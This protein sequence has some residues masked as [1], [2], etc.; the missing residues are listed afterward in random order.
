[1]LVPK[2]L[3]K[4]V[5]DALNWSAVDTVTVSVKA[6]QQMCEPCTIQ[7]TFSAVSVKPYGENL[8]IA[9]MGRVVN[10]LPEIT[11]PQLPAGHETTVGFSDT[12][13]DDGTIF[14]FLHN[15][16]ISSGAED[17]DTFAGKF[18][19]QAYQYLVFVNLPVAPKPEDIK[20]H[21]MRTNY[22]RRANFSCSD[23]DL[24]AIHD[25]VAYTTENLAFNGYMVDCG[26]L[27]KH[28]YGGDG[29]ASTLTVQT[30]YEVA[31][32]YY[33][34]L[35][36]WNDVVREDG[37]LPNTAPSTHPAGGGPYW[38]S[39]IIQAPW[40]TYMSYADDRNLA[41]GYPYMKQWL[42]FAEQSIEDGLYFRSAN[43]KDWGLGDW[44]APKGVDVKNPESI[45][46]VN[47]CTMSQCLRDMA[48]IAGHLGMKQDSISYA[49]RLEALNQNIHQTFY[50][51]DGKYGTGSQID[52]AFPLLVGAVPDSLVELAEN[53]LIERTA[54]L[55]DNHFACG[56][57]GIP[58]LTEWATLA[59]K[60]DFIYNMLKQN[61]YPG[62]LYMKN[63]G[64]KAVWE[65]WNGERSRLHNCYNGIESWFYQALGGIIPTQ[66]GYKRVTINP[67]TPK[68]ISWV[69]VSEET[70][71]G[72][73]H[74]RWKRN[75]NI[76][77]MEVT[78]PVGLTADIFG[79]TYGNGMYTIEF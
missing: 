23:A 25:M 26:S 2:A 38:C 63:N 45:D 46:L 79:K 10:G 65:S 74:V 66:P 61:D 72:N 27:E 21:R 12:K 32:L 48:Q 70:P 60:C 4:E 77:I 24:C 73:L 1:M 78:I 57:V 37:S 31:P 18:I 52:M 34:W 54:K 7:E 20:V 59:G 49:T 15:T 13:F 69:E 44:L 50:H 33:N 41:K 58:V 17:G 11:L 56:L 16:Y 14:T 40:R 64:A 22:P 35:Q 76:R 67:Q 29:N 36:A 75:E 47:N 68:D 8:W 28:G 42:A 62:Y 6:V 51:N 53:T 43:G 55:H 71:Y 9:D 19:Q 3:T 30:L 39:F 5:L